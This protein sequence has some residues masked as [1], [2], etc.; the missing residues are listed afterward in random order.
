MLNLHS[1]TWGR[2]GDDD[3]ACSGGDG[4]KRP[5]PTTRTTPI[6]RTAAGRAC[7][8]TTATTAATCCRT[9]AGCRRPHACHGYRIVTDNR[10]ARAART[11]TTGI[12]PSSTGHKRTSSARTTSRGQTS[13]SAT[14]ATTV[15]TGGQ[16]IAVAAPTTCTAWPTCTTTTATRQNSYTARPTIAP[17]IADTASGWEPG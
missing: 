12:G 4:R 5:A 13:S 16:G 2:V 11:T 9:R 17:R 8:R 6:G 3:D 14:T 1:W 7:R 15:R 10:A